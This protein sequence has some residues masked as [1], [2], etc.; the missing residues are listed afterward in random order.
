M[1][2]QILNELVENQLKDVLPEYKLNIKDI[3]RIRKKISTSIFD[4]KKCCMWEGYIIHR[5]NKNPNSR[6]FFR[7][8]RRSLH[9]ILYSNYVE[10]LK[11][12]EYIKFNCKNGGECCNINHF[13]KYKY[14]T[15]KNFKKRIIPSQKKNINIEHNI[16]LNFD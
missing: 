9:R 3:I 14:V 13:C 2:D 8:E 4:K 6:Y 16:I 12:N 11:D 10:E 15:K 7:S 1:K 5:K